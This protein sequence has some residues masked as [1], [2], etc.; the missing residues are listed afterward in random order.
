M[1]R[2]RLWPQNLEY[3]E[4]AIYLCTHCI[5]IEHVIMPCIVGDM[6]YLSKY[7]QLSCCVIY[8]EF[9]LQYLESLFT[10]AVSSWCEPS[11]ENF[12]AQQRRCLEVYNVKIMKRA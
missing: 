6:N 4:F 5:T 2:I 1:S 8:W 11:G 3:E 12:S 10:K 7:N 9:D